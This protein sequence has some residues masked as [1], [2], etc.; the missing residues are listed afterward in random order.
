MGYPCP[1]FCLCAFFG[2]R[3]VIFGK[4]FFLTFSFFAAAK[5]C[6]SFLHECDCRPGPRPCATKAY[7]VN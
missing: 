1:N 4:L 5:A 7:I 3:T 2:A 6:L